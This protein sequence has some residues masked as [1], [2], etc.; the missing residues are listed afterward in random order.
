MER[1]VKGTKYMVA[2]CDGSQSA[3]GGVGGGGGEEETQ[4][5]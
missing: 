3:G 1:E 2:N 4:L 5:T